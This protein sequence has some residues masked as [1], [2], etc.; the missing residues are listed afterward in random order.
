M[1]RFRQCIADYLTTPSN[2]PHDLT[3]ATTPANARG[4][5][6]ANALKYATAFPVII[7]SAMQTSSDFFAKLSPEEAAEAGVWLGPSSLFNI[8]ILAVFVNSLYSFWWDATNDWGLHILLPSAWKTARDAGK[9]FV[10]GHLRRMST[11][12]GDASPSKTGAKYTQ[13]HSRAWS[14]AS[15]TS[16]NP[17]FPHLKDSTD[18]LK[19][20]TNGHAFASSSHHFLRPQLL[21]PDPSLY[22]TI[23][24]IDLL[25]RG[26]WSLKLSTHLHSIHELEQGIWLL[27]A[28][29]VVRRWMWTFVRIE[30]EVVKRSSAQPIPTNGSSAIDLH[31]L[32]RGLT[33][34]DEAMLRDR[35]Q[36]NPDSMQQR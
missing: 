26:T 3:L 27:E 30:W 35:K 9:E 19:R 16:S 15:S 10:R 18:D 17:A 28:L 2:Q 13:L 5:S 33:A 11:P 4:R 32:D 20:S 6:L 34:G 12:F 22:Y 1:I 24:A 8:W 31:R 29:E 21:L 23:V 7:F 36:S 14:L 25:L